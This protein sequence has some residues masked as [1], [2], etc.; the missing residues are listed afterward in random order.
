V[1]LLQETERVAAIGLACSWHPG[2]GAAAAAARVAGLFP[3]SW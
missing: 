2:S 3:T 1:G